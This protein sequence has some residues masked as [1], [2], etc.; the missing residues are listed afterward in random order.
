MPTASCS[1]V[2]VRRWIAP[3]VPVAL[4]AVPATRRLDEP[5]VLIREVVRHPVH[6][7]SD[8]PPVSLPQ[9]VVEV[10]HGAEERIDIGVVGYVVA[11]IGHRRPVERRQPDGG[12]AQRAIGAVV[13]VIEMFGN[14]AQITNAVPVRVGETARVDLVDHAA[15][16]S[17]AQLRFTHASPYRPAQADPAVAVAGHM[18]IVQVHVVA[19]VGVG[20]EVERRLLRVMF[21][22]ELQAGRAGRLG[23]ART[24]CCRCVRWP[25]ALGHGPADVEYLVVAGA[26]LL[27]FAP[28]VQ[29]ALEPGRSCW[30]GSASPCPGWRSSWPG[31]RRHPWR[32][33]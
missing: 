1:A 5:R 19:V 17:G 12:N 26:D 25:G 3:Y 32:C 2:P 23:C 14:A 28:R 30:P 9:Q 22:P 11:E 20:D 10:L 33:S 18:D 13:Q 7:D 4:G 21:G 24:R 8:S 31:S 16:P 6:D 27:A 29:D 15:L